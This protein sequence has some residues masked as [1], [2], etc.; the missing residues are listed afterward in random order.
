MKEKNDLVFIFVF[1]RIELVLAI[2]TY[3]LH[4]YFCYPLGLTRGLQRDSHYSR[5]LDD[6]CVYSYQL[7]SYIYIF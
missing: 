7:D 5:F 3:S 6:K 4:S 2:E 1:F